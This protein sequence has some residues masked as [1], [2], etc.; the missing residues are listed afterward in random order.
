MRRGV[1]REVDR[2][3]L[4]RWFGWKNN[5]EGLMAARDARLQDKSVS[6]FVSP[7]MHVVSRGKADWARKV[8][9]KGDEVDEYTAERR[10]SS[11]LTRL[12][13]SSGRSGTRPASK[14]DR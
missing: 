1:L 4:F 8:W 12:P 5:D 10:T 13:L 7:V 9:T 14:G 3:S 2:D 11:L 6:A